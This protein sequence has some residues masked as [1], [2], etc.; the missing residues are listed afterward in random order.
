[1]ARP[2]AVAVSSTRYSAWPTSTSAI[3]PDRREV[4]TAITGSSSKS[5]SGDA[6]RAGAAGEVAQHPASPWG[7]RTSRIAASRR[8]AGVTPDRDRAGARRVRATVAPAS[9]SVVVSRPATR[10]GGPV[11]PHPGRRACSRQV[12]R[13]GPAPHP[14]RQRTPCACRAV[15]ACARRPGSLARDGTLAPTG[16]APAASMLT[17]PRCTPGPPRGS[18]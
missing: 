4:G 6:G 16:S 17:T 8:S 3:G 15:D 14:A 12:G 5:L 2:S 18:R 9:G 13:P 1:M 7:S 10:R 11:P